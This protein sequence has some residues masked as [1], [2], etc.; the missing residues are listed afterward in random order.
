MTCMVT[1][2]GK[3]LV[4]VLSHTLIGISSLGCVQPLWCLGL[5]PYDQ[6]RYLETEAI[7]KASMPK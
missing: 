3:H 2:P 4:Q 1:E 7:R 6:R 5:M